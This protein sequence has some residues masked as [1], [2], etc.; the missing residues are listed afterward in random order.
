MKTEALGRLTIPGLYQLA[1]AVN[2]TSTRSRMT[3]QQLVA[4]LMDSPTAT[5][6]QMRYAR[7]LAM[8]RGLP[9]DYMKFATK[10][11]T[12]CYIDSFKEE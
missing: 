2:P 4:V 10:R 5:G 7:S 1:K 8:E 11:L 9:L 12:S 6:A 3:K